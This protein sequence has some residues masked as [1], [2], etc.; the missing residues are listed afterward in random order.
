MSG[1]A[2]LGAAARP[3]VWR[4]KPTPAR[5]LAVGAWTAALAAI[6]FLV[7]TSVAG[8]MLDLDVYRT[9]GQAIL[10][11]GNLYSIRSADNLLF[12]YPPVS[13]VLAVPLALVPFDVAKVAWVAM[14][15]G[16]LLLA[17]QAGFRPLLRRASG[18]AA[19]VLPVILA[20]SAY[21]LP[22]RQDFG[23]GQVDL[24]LLMLCLVDCLA[25]SPR[26]PRGLLIGLATAIKLEPGVFIVYLLITRRRH[27]AGVA[28]LTFAGWTA[29]AWL[30]SPRDSAVY[31]TSAIFDNKRLGGFGSAGNQA[32]RG[33]VWRLHLGSGATDAIW[34]LLALVVG[35]AGF[36]AAR[37][38]WLRGHEMAAITITGL[39]G[40]LLSPV[41]WIHHLCW[42]VV[43][44][45]VIAGDCRKAARIW[46]A[47]LTGVLFLTTLPIWAEVNLSA[48]Q[49]RSV[50]GFVL[51]NSFGLWAL[52]LIPVLFWIGVSPGIAGSDA[53]EPALDAENAAATVRLPSAPGNAALSTVSVDAPGGRYGRHW[54]R[55]VPFRWG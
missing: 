2:W 37:A 35:V 12:T 14:L 47:A 7:A 27:E 38:S 43:A 49:L 45:G 21:L 5:L 4:L 52:A 36:A 22:V 32:L 18:A 24:F 23:F 28:A 54:A 55:R 31:W 34:L 1:L 25:E 10:H 39:L 19:V 9:G 16:P 44:I 50:P 30:I 40:A 48:A 13:A 29:L 51:E 46:L 6:G 26:W 42:I 8:R 15:I 33:M 20:I 41:A 17:V 3:A 53:G 11:G